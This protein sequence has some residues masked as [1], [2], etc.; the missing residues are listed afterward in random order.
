MTV[1]VP[2]GP[3]TAADECC[4]PCTWPDTPC[5]VN[6]PAAAPGG[7]DRGVRERDAGR[8]DD[9]VVSADVYW[10]VCDENDRL[11]AAAAAAP[12]GAAA[13]PRL[14]VEC[15]KCHAQPGEPC[16]TGG[17][18]PVGDLPGDVRPEG[19]HR[20][21]VA[22]GGAEPA[23]DP[24]RQAEIADAIQRTAA[25]IADTQAFLRGDMSEADYLT[26]H[27][28]LAPEPATEPEYVSQCLAC[29]YETT[30]P[31]PVR[32]RHA[33]SPEPTDRE[34]L[35][36][37]WDLVKDCDFTAHQATCQH[38]DFCPYQVLTQIR[39][40]LVVDPPAPE[41]ERAEGQR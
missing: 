28:P 10:Q 7:A 2:G 16:T 41:P 13:D 17:Y 30:H 39:A 11:R 3:E 24:T 29:S 1:P 21:R 35:R 6:G 4:R 18:L 36:R 19:P 15:P 5:Y 32:H 20:Q 37:A 40:A 27:A 14:T 34:G 9:P 26:K 23:T 22:P 33:P 31:H 38:E 25:T 12:G 8:W